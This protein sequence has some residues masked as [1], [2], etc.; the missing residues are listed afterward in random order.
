MNKVF[1]IIK[2]EFLVD[3]LGLSHF[4]PSN[5]LTVYL[6]ILFQSHTLRDVER[7]GGLWQP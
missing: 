5:F 2:Y 1:V 7:R 3:R 4:R 6:A